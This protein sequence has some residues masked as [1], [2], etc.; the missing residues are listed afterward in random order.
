[1][2]NITSNKGVHITFKNG[3]TV[4]VQWGYGDYC[5]NRYSGHFGETPPESHDAEVAVWDADNVWVTK[6]APHSENDDVIGY[7]NADQVADIIA[8]ASMLKTR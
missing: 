1:M 2:F 7:L 6:D 3:I 5:D 4:S 8:W